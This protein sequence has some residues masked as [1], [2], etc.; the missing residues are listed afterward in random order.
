M[1][2]IALILTKNTMKV[3]LKFLNLIKNPWAHLIFLALL[4]ILL[5]SQSTIYLMDDSYYYQ[6]FT[7][8]LV[9]EGQVDF[10]LPGFHG[11]DFLTAPIYLITRSPFSVAILD[12]IAAILNIFLIYLATREIFRNEKLGVF[13]AYIYVL[14]PLD[15]SNPLRGHHHTPLIMLILLGLYLLFRNSK[16]TFLAFGLSYIVRPFGIA[17]APLF[18][19]KKKIGQFFLSLTI[20]AAYL[21]GEY[22]QIGKIHIGVH[23]NLTPTTLFSPQRFILNLGYAFQNYF[24][25]HNYSFLNRLDTADM[26]HLSPFITFLALIGVLYHQKFF[27]DKKLFLA[28]LASSV[29]ALVIPASFFHLDMWHLWT[30]NLTLILLALPVIMKFT[31]L[32]PFIVLSFFFQ[33]FY[34]YLTFRDVFWH[35]YTIFVIPA[36]ILIISLIYTYYQIIFIKN[37]NSNCC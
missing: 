16:L 18:L 12:I 36:S 3:N 7:E 6:R 5:Y 15:Y 14:N 30:F 1:I 37:E 27:T 25:I 29:I 9:N 17:L 23:T 11:A 21:I 28:L 8:K 33:F 2:F 4:L 35:N 13:A 32:I 31:K 24:S 34:T 20:P 22:W 19:Y 26:I 10:S